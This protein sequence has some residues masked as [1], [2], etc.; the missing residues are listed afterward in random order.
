MTNKE[1]GQLFLEVLEEDD[2]RSSRRIR[3]RVNV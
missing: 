1:M 2:N 3:R